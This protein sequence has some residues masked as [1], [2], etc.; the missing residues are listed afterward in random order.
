MSAL[1]ER[2][3]EILNRGS[4]ICGKAP[5]ESLVHKREQYF[6]DLFIEQLGIS[7]V[8]L[9]GA[10]WTLVFGNL[11]KRG[12]QAVGCD[13]FM[14]LVEERRKEYG[15]DTFYSPV[16]LPEKPFDLISAFEVF[17]HFLEPGREVKFLVDRLKPEG[18]VFG[19]TDFWHGGKLSEHPS[20][21]RTYWQHK[22]HVTAWSWP[23]MRCL[24]KRC[25]LNATFFKVDRAG[26]GTKVFFALHRGD[27][28]NGALA[29]LPKVFEKAF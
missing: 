5:P 22:S 2:D 8:L 20:R 29:K 21:D 10:G 4:S 27:S 7:D 23:S 12:I 1:S 14:P 24:A 11:R 17:E 25:G 18:C 13:L 9:Y 3:R 28:W 26:F 6:C 16:D 15:K 19:C